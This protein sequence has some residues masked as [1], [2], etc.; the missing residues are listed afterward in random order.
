MTLVLDVMTRRV[1][2]ISLDDS[3]RRIRSIFNQV[4]FHHILVLEGKVLMGVISDRD[5]LKHLSPRL[6][7]GF[8]TQADL[9]TLDKKAHQ[10]MSRRPV[11]VTADASIDYA[12][13]LLLE[14]N[15]SCLPVVDE[16]DVLIG[17]LSWKDIL[18]HTTKCK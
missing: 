5:L 8:E 15:V 12:A 10:I 7:S 16:N 2:S 3:L 11:T 17:I 18:R 13:G 4:K 9:S 14:R 1:V 6:G